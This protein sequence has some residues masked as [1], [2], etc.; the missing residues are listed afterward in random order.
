M[1]ARLTSAKT[2]QKE[3]R[4]QLLATQ[5]SR[6][7]IAKNMSQKEKEWHSTKKARR[8]MAHLNIWL[9]DLEESKMEVSGEDDDSVDKIPTKLGDDYMSILSALRLIEPMHTDGGTDRTMEEVNML[10][11]LCEKEGVFDDVE[12]DGEDEDD[13]ES[14]SSVHTSD[15]DSSEL[16]SLSG[17]LSDGLSDDD[18]PAGLSTRGISSNS[19][20]ASLKSLGV[21][22]GTGDASPST[23][24]DSIS[25]RDISP[26]NRDISP[27]SG[28]SLSKDGSNI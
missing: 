17:D 11:E 25:T 24:Q 13:I 20:D 18:R 3:L 5:T 14:V 6:S 7:E 15:I 19:Q 8:E 10:Y 16:E 21:S 22:L 12:E 1:L 26:S 2:Q 27:S 28:I 9:H 4:A 23:R